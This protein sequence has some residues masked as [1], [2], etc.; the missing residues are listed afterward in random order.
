MKIC[1]PNEHRV[2]FSEGVHYRPARI[3]PGPALLAPHFP[4][5]HPRLNLYGSVLQTAAG[6]EMFYQCG[7]AMRVGY[8]R[9]A[10][11]EH[12]ER[13]CFNVTDLNAHAHQIILG[14]AGVDP[15]DAPALGEGQTLTN[16]VAGYHMPSVLYEPDSPQPYKMFAFGE[17]GYHSLWSEDGCHF[18]RYQEDP[19][20]PLILTENSLSAKKWASDVAPCFHDGQQYVAMV[21]TYQEDWQGRTRRCIGRSVSEDFIHWS[22][23]QTVWVPGDAEDRIAQERGY[24]W[25]DFYGLCPFAYGEGYLGFLW[26]FEID[27]EWEKGTHLGK[28]ETFLA[29]S[30][31]GKQWQRLGDEA[32]LPWDLNF[33]EQGGMM[34]TASAPVFRP[35]GVDIYYSDSN[36]EH[37]Y[38]EAEFGKPL[39]DPTWVIRKVTLAPDRLVGAHGQGMLV[40]YPMTFDARELEVNIDCREGRVVLHWLPESDWQP[41]RGNG[42]AARLPENWRQRCHHHFGLNGMDALTQSVPSPVE[43]NYWLIVELDNASLFAISQPDEPV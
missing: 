40:L 17:G 15:V 30:P 25:A 41:G 6:F 35:D 7:N 32:F 16:I 34:T 8:A 11:G 10:D 43:G 29:Y 20:I 28:M 31:D 19:V 23:P 21:K 4:W 37:G 1:F 27:H 3:G 12:W 22:E 36:Y 33:A 18:Q 42:N 39:Q 24:P 5:E 2:A 13:P 14:H 38:A 9:S 26:L